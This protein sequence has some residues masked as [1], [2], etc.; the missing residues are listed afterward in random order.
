MDKG[1]VA[2]KPQAE[3]IKEENSTSETNRRGHNTNFQGK[4]SQTGQKAPTEALQATKLA[5]EKIEEI[6]EAEN[7]TGSRLRIKIMG[8]GCAGFS[9]DMSF[10]EKLVE[11]DGEEKVLP[12]L[13]EDPVK[14]FDFLFTFGDNI[15][16]VVDQMSLMYMYGTKIDY[17]DELMGAGFK[18]DNPNVKN[19]CGCGSSFN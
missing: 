18:F 14:G 4:E 13:A 19:T 16:I 8:G 17:V 15:N 9:Y 11:E 2:N 3:K 7:L 10:D 1:E 6:C 5:I 12:C